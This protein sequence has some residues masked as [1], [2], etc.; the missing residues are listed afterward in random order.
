[1][2]VGATAG[3]SALGRAT[4]RLAEAQV[5][6]S[7][8]VP[9]RCR[10]ETLVPSASATTER[11]PNYRCTLSERCEYDTVSRTCRETSPT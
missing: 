5:A 4:A 6:L 1:M 2:V 11:E 9:T 8:R 10:E 7:Q 3:Y